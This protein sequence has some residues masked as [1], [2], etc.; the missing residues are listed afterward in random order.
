MLQA[1][2]HSEITREDERLA[3]ESK[4]LRHHKASK[5]AVRLPTAVHKLVAEENK[6]N[7]GNH[8][9]ITGR[10]AHLARLKRKHAAAEMADKLKSTT[11]KSMPIK[12][13]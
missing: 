6:N 1:K 8:H 4:L 5:A 9:D 11:V 3:G 2:L 12:N 13:K 7:N 10:Q